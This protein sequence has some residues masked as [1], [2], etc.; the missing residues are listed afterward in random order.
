MAGK[1]VYYTKNKKKK[2]D[3]RDMYKHSHCNCW[4][5]NP[6]AR[7]SRRLRYVE[8]GEE[9]HATATTGEIKPLEKQCKGGRGG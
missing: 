6:C 4:S 7:Q 8:G 9:V 2:A 3:K 1:T 5:A